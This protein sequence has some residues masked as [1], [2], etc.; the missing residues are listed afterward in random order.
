[1]A[2]ERELRRIGTLNI[3]HE[4]L[5][6][7]LHFPDTEDLLA[8]LGSGDLNS[9]QLAAA[10]NALLEPAET[11]ALQLPLRAPHRAGGGAGDVRIQGVGNL[12]TQTARCCKP[13]PDDPIV[14]YITRGRG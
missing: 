12:L 2:L 4:K 13:V 3:S 7:Q 11:P 8:A 10:I 6:Q 14:G 1:T 9:S 5:A